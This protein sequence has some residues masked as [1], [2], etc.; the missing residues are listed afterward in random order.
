MTNKHYQ[1]G[2]T[3]EKRVQKY[4]E[5][6]DFFVVRS[7]GSKGVADLVVIRPYRL[8][9]FVQ[10][11]YGKNITTEEKMKLRDKCEDLNVRGLIAYGRPREKISFIDV[12]TG[13]EANY[14]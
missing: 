13:I 3:F 12:F 6:R 2:Y 9:I 8:P 14:V 1:K 10:C 11:K 5:E 4:F 7:A